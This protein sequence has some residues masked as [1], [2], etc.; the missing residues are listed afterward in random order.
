MV[1]ATRALL[2]LV[3]LACA[4]QAMAATSHWVKCGTVET[5]ASWENGVCATVTVTNPAKTASLTWA[6]HLSVSG[7]NLTTGPSGIGSVETVRGW[8]HSCPHR[9]PADPAHALSQLLAGF[10]RGGRVSATQDL[11]QSRMPSKVV[12]TP[13]TRSWTRTA[14]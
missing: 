14:T 8:A 11:E 4:S 5:T 6:A 9:C 10:D 3:A 7:L 1:S 2:L 12:H 13:L